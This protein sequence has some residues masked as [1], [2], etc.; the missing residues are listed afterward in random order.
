MFLPLTEPAR[1][2]GA[3]GGRGSGKSHFFCEELVVDCLDHKGMVAGCFREVQKDL[4]HSS[5]ALV[6]KKIRDLGVQNS[7]RI[8]NDRI[9][10]PGD[11][12]I[13]FQGLRDHTAESVKSLEGLKRAFLEEA[14]NVSEHSLSLLRP[15]IREE[16]SEIWY[17]WNP[18][19]KTDA[20]D[21]FLR[22]LRPQ[23]SIVVKANWSDNPF[24][25]N[26][27]NDERL[28]DL[29]LYPDRYDHI[30]GGGYVKALAGAYYSPHLAAAQLAGRIIP[31]TPDPIMRLRCFWD[32]GGAGAKADNM[33]I[34]VTQFVGHD[35]WLLNYI[36]GQGQVLAYYVNE[37]RTRGFG[38]AD[39]ILPHDGVNTNS[40]TGKRYEDH[41]REAFPDSDV[42]VIPNQGQG[43]A[44]MRIEAGRRVFPRVWF[45]CGPCKSG[46]GKTIADATE[47]GRDSLGYYHEKKDQ[48]RDVGLGPNHD[49]SS[50]GA[51]SFGLMAVCY[52]VPKTKRT[53]ASG[54]QRIGRSGPHSWM[55]S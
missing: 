6:E 41:L 50:H 7:F 31:L 24:F 4:K 32:I 54:Q 12:V 53:N 26:T 51:D 16:G 15:T 36:E 43:A 22:T 35:I 42:K 40:I 45:N 38:N 14:Q 33:A 5:K 25:P 34:W 49:W 27:L 2:K 48:H 1:H 29:R 30:W 11:G 39:H 47:A 37:L 23:N 19:R 44:M 8:Y 55:G 21:N 17:A 28:E 10:T 9:G 46:D 18:R 3:W 20:V 13:L 52:E